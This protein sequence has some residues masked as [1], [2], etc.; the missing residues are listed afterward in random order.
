MNQRHPLLLLTVLALSLLSA[1]YGLGISFDRWVDSM[2]HSGNFAGIGPDGWISHQGRMDFPGLFNIGNRLTIQF[3]RW[4]PPVAP[5]TIVKISV[6]S[7]PS[8]DF[9]IEGGTRIGL[10]LRG[11]CDPRRVSFDVPQP[12]VA[13]GRDKRE[14]GAQ[15]E[16][17]HIWS[18]L[19]V[20][21][22]ASA[23][24]AEV[25]LALFLLALLVSF[26]F[27][28]SLWGW[29]AA[30][31]VPLAAFPMILVTPYG[32]L[33]QPQ[34]LWALSVMLALGLCVGAARRGDKVGT[35]FSF[36]GSQPVDSRIWPM[37]V[38]GL[39]LAGAALRLYGIDFGLPNNYHPDEVPKVNA[40]EYMRAQGSLDPNYFLH[41]S[42]LL[43]VTYFTSTI[44]QYFDG[45]ADFRI[46]T[47][48][49]GRIVSALAGSASIYLLFLV[50]RRLYS[51]V[52]GVMAA[53]MLTFFPLHVTCSRYL[54]EDSLLCFFL[55][56]SLV[57]MLKS[58]KEDNKW[59]LYL[60][61]A[62]AGF[63]ASTKY[64]G[65]LTA[66]VVVVAPFL[67]SQSWK[68]DRRFVEHAFWALLIVPL[69]FVIGSPFVVLNIRKF[70]SDFRFEKRHMLRGHTQAI[71][72]WSQYW[73][74]H[75][76]RSV[77]PGMTAFGALAATAGMGV[78]LWRRRI[79]DL[80]VVGLILAFYLPAEWVKAKPAP[81][82]ER[83]ILPCLPFMALAAAET[84]RILWCSKAR[85]LA[86]VGGAAL[87]L[88]PMLRSLDLARDIKDDTRLQA[89]RWMIEHLPKGSPIYLD[90]QPYTS[91]FTEDQ[92]NVEFVFR[93]GVV[94]LLTLTALKESGKK[95]LL[96]SS[97]FYDRYF[98]D[99][100]GDRAA[101]A[102]LRG[103]FQGVPI[104]KEFLAPSGTYGFHNP[105]LTL[106]S[107][108]PAEFAKLDAEIAAK[109][110]GQQVATSNE[111]KTVFRW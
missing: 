37:L 48:L 103:I 46:S 86:L 62:A 35:A 6:C 100:N 72:A 16:S 39:V 77:V 66:G 34:W 92:F 97:L 104:I 61:A 7:E 32:Q 64:S 67:R 98:S 42:L 99:P 33:E 85:L 102:R 84:V 75:F 76:S 88:L 5:K 12:F 89:A 40:I 24:I 49:A 27:R 106:F 108:D 51:S 1:V 25:A 78:L 47:F 52:V 60:A 28:H 71:D 94:D 63:S 14:L 93:E 15:I 38:I 55:L 101:K 57:W 65:F 26:A 59:Y 3:A 41:P 58:V 68:P 11:V 107:L 29:L 91:Y 36:V 20:P 70:L 45:G 30:A 111:A 69:C 31:A 79:E 18:L 87:C 95:Y 110:D 2:V 44:V 50:G 8:G 105:R 23:H 82:P 81:Q 83:Y 22:V 9:L 43:Y 19:G 109:G 21:L 73:M 74:Y 56:L 80:F 53:A 96:I 13:P 4:R 10:S 90:W 54:K 17:L